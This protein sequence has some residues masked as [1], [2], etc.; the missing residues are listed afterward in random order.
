MTAPFASK[1]RSRNFPRGL[2]A[3]RKL[4]VG[5]RRYM[6]LP[7]EIDPLDKSIIRPTERTPYRP[8]PLA[9]EEG[10]PT[11]L[12]EVRAL[13]SKADHAASNPH[14]RAAA[15]NLLRFLYT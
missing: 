12:G 8:L 5:D 14:D 4:K 15:G 9:G 11:Q 6:E 13:G 2:S 7:G 10:A 3:Y 1:G